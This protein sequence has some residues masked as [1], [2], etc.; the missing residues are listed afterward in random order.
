MNAISRSLRP[1]LLSLTLTLATAL[2]VAAGGPMGTLRT[3]P[4]ADADW[5]DRLIVRLRDPG[6][7]DPDRRIA[8]IAGRAGE[9]L[10]RL[11]GMSGGSHVVQMSRAVSPAEAR[12]TARRLALDPW[13]DSVEPDLRMRPQAT[14]ND[15]LY[16]YQWNYFEAAGGI[17]LP[18]AWDVTVGS[19]NITVGVIDT[20][21]LKHA[22]LAIRLVPGF[23]FIR[24]ASVSNDGDGRDSDA[25]DAG[26]HGCNGSASSWHG[27]HVAGIIGAASNN[28]AG[29]A[30]VNWGSKILPARALG[31]C[32]G[33]TSDIVDAMRWSAGIAVA[34]A[35]VNAT[36]ARV[37]NLSLGGA[38]ACGAAFQNA[39]NDVTAR[40]TVVVVAAGNANTDA[41][42]TA[43]ANCLGV[44]TVAA[45]TRSGAK[46]SYSN[47]GSKV[48]IAA[49]G[50][51]SGDGIL[52][53]L[54]TGATVP[55]AD[56]YA[57]YQG[58]SMATPHVT[59][60][61]SLMLS[62][63]PS[64]TPAQVL[65]KLQ[66]SARAFPTGTGA[67]C[68]P[69]LCGAG[70]VN[71]AAALSG[72]APA[73]Q[74][75]PTGRLNLALAANGGVASASSTAAAIYPPTAA[76]NGDR[77]G[78]GWHA[79]GGWADG[80]P[81]AWPD[82][83]QV[84]FGA[85]RTV[86]EIDVFSIQDDYMNPQEPTEA[87][88]FS[89]YGL[90]GFEVQYWTGALWQTVPGGSV[91]GNNRVW[92]KFTFAPV[93]T[94]SIRVLVTGAPDSYSRLAEGRGLRGGGFA[95]CDS[96]ADQR[97]GAG[98]RRRRLRFQ[99]GGSAL[100]RHGGQRRQP[101]GQRLGTGWRLGRW[102]AGDM[103]GRRPGEFRRHPEHHGNQLVL[104]PGQLPKSA[105][106]HPGDDLQ[107]LRAHRLRPAVLG[108]VD[109][110][111]SAR[112]Q[113]ERER[114]GLA[115]SLPGD[116]HGEHS[117]GGAASVRRVQQNRGDRGDRQPLT[118]D[119]MPHAGA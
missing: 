97:G 16:P 98:Q 17:N 34:G 92:R 87:M 22:D 113:R 47:F 66:S 82:W 55:A 6:E 58:T 15:A 13:V 99:H 76:N 38:G 83:L 26:D 40:G 86:A 18:S 62:A 67:D 71:A 42:G 117:G 25:S 41:A 115:Q 4:G 107:P 20:G 112:R 80:S 21:V 53:T 45:T 74:P 81:G 61:V 75:P 93:S 94:S 44:I 103:A 114:Q 30:G 60:V 91:T 12:A 52:S 109:V 19:A 69:A 119:G 46:A 90:T 110:G 89:Q 5:T 14:P 36:P 63:D 96:G 95:A 72:S 31:R 39:V 77:R 70:I 10:S 111:G 2:P 35:P 79:G 102:N 48:A 108:R 32:G 29:V 104:D 23:D 59:A 65:A 54:N 27:T 106:P 24:D 28:G 118:A 33:Y 64:L 116:R 3:T 1:T 100:P 7:R 88:T 84:D 68:S 11:R 9:R 101:P 51:G 73:P 49:P 50:G 37:L 56:S 78:N 43:P 85:A 105:E 8:E 57:Y